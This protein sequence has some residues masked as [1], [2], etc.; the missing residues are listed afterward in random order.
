MGQISTEPGNNAVTLWPKLQGIETEG[1]GY[2]EWGPCDSR[3]DAVGS[4]AG[5]SKPGKK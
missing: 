5:A 3:V 1:R 4:V 2:K